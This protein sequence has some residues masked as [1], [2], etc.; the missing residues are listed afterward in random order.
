VTSW[1][2]SSGVAGPLPLGAGVNEEVGAGGVLDGAALGGGVGV[3]GTVADAG[4]VPLG[5]RARGAVVEVA[6]CLDDLQP[7]TKRTEQSTVL[8]TAV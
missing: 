8:S 4:A 1:H 2:G 7:V 3:E 6:A 5:T